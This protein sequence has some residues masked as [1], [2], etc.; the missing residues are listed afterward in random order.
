L[1]YRR[2]LRDAVIELI[3][4]LTLCLLLLLDLLN[5]VFLELDIR[6]QAIQMRIAFIRLALVRT[7]EAGGA[8]WT[9]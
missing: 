8:G 6:V 7:L 9:R 3:E 5:L 1:L 4:P 2:L